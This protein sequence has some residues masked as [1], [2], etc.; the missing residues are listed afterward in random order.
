M[1]HLLW[2][3]IKHAPLLF[4]LVC[5][6]IIYGQ[7]VL[8][9]EERANKPYYFG[10][11]LGG[12]SATLLPLK[13]PLFFANDSILRAE[14]GVSPGYSVRLLGTLK[15]NNRL[16]LRLNPG[17]ILGVDRTFTYTLGSRQLFENEI[18]TKVIQSNIATFPVQLKF[19]SDRI[20]NFKVYMLGGFKLDYDLA[21][22]SGSRNAED[23]IKLKKADFGAELGIG[24]NFFLPFVT[25]S[26]EIKFSN[27][28][29]NLH[30]R[31]ANLK[32]SNI[33]DKMYSRMIQF[34]IHLE[35]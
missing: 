25:V 31:D 3:K 14:P 28:F 20:Q 1:H 29:T 22:N 4:L 12:A 33:F 30:S 32:Y 16:E 34:S 6:Q 18:E 8:H 27:G 26:P 5:T 23:L 24:F 21:S 7:K 9:R 11:T 13:S 2:P 19:N 10:L 35:E 17:L 15:L